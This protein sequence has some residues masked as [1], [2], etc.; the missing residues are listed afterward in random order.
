MSAAK[1]TFA[2]C[3]KQTCHVSIIMGNRVYGWPYFIVCNCKSIIFPQNKHR[4]THFMDVLVEL[5]YIFGQYILQSFVYRGLC[6]V[7]FVEPFIDHIRRR[8]RS[9]EHGTGAI[10]IT[11]QESILALEL[12]WIIERILAAFIL[13]LY[14]LTFYGR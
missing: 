3:K 8:Y 6:P 10:D 7:Q 2:F 11:I 9:F 13:Y 12:G 14:Q 4:L 5:G 1:I